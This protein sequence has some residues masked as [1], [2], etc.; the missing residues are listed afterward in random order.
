MGASEAYL[1]RDSGLGISTPSIA[2]SNPD[3]LHIFEN[4]SRIKP[5]NPRLAYLQYNLGTV[6][7]FRISLKDT[8][9]WVGVRNFGTSHGSSWKASSIIAI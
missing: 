9:N 8:R 5:L 7:S 4:Q 2:L 6:G 1:S 3:L